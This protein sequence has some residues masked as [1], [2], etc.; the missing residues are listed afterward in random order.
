MPDLVHCPVCYQ[1]LRM[2]AVFTVNG[3]TLFNKDGSIF[4]RFNRWEADEILCQLGRT[5]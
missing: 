2:T 5:T 3:V 1:G 4:T